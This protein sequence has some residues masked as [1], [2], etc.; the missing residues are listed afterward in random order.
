[1]STPTAPVVDVFF[2]AGDALVD[3]LGRLD[4]A[5]WDKPSALEGYTVGGLAAHASRALLT[6]DRYLA[7]PPPP[8]DAAVVD[9]AGYLADVLADHD[10]RDSAFHVG[11][12]ER[13]T[14]AS[15]HGPESVEADARAA[16]AKLRTTLPA[17]PGD[18][19]LEVRNGVATTLE[20]YLRT[21]IV[22]LVV[23]L[24]DLLASVDHSPPEL[25][26]G[27]WTVTAEVLAATAVRRAGGPA[28][29]R[30]LARAERHPEAVRAL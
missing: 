9:A 17:T 26:V 19:P 16:L 23:H 21:R 24:D 30:S 18:H 13:A 2:A 10:P 22:E 29:V 1:M 7:A 15:Q 14:T 6:V 25:P 20:E 28:T 4:A 3:L 8:S 27:A 11:V 12:R 5:A